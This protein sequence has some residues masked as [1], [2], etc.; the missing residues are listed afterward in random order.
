MKET[1]LKKVMMEIIGRYGMI[2]LID[3]EPAP[4][5][6]FVLYRDDVF[7]SWK[8][9]VGGE[10]IGSTP[11]PA[12]RLQGDLNE[13]RFQAH[14]DASQ[15]QTTVAYATW[16]GAT[17][18]PDEGRIVFPSV[19][20]VRNVWMPLAALALEKD[21][22]S[23]P[24]KYSNGSVVYYHLIINGRNW[25]DASP[26]KYPV[27]RNQR[28]VRVASHENIESVDVNINDSDVT[29]WITRCSIETYEGFINPVYCEPLS[30]RLYMKCTRR[31]G[32]VR[33]E[34]EL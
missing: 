20:E 13:I 9:L 19:R 30:K 28:C 22:A 12:Y 16:M 11:D 18:Y 23:V 26:A 7:G 14:T 17:I 31:D 33:W 27:F 4:K 25:H 1:R 21:D 15:R 5:G 29:L 10:M 2:N 24:V 3:H 32:S 8:D 34:P 6:K